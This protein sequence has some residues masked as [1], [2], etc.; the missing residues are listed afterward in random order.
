MSW[1][2][3]TGSALVAA[4]V[5]LFVLLTAF[6]CVQ[7]QRRTA[8][9][10]LAKAQS[11]REEILS[12]PQASS[13]KEELDLSA[14]YQEK[15]ESY[16]TKSRSTSS[17]ELQ[18]VRD[19]YDTWAE[20]MADLSLKKAREARTK[21]QGDRE[22]PPVE[23]PP[24]AAGE[25]KEEEDSSGPPGPLSLGRNKEPAGED[26]PAEKNRV[27]E[28]SLKA[29]PQAEVINPA[30][31]DLQGPQGPLKAD[32][33]TPQASPDSTTPPDRTS[34]EPT[35]GKNVAEKT[36][37]AREEEDRTARPPVPP[38]AEPVT[39]PRELYA[40]ALALYYDHDYNSSR[41]LF[42]A[43]LAQH[44][45][46]ALAVNSQYWIGETY[47]SEAEYVLALGAFEAVVNQYPDGVK[48]PDG[49]VKM[50]LSE[51]KLGRLRQGRK[52]LEE[53]LAR[54]PKSP[55]AK[56]ARRYLDTLSQ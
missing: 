44:P 3:R 10:K 55:A 14:R 53:C 20:Q 39:E 49:M 15:A 2:N 54:F 52:A 12:H 45:D 36:A 56:V 11:L 21:L 34:E 9:S 29:P 26:R 25:G 42:L 35:E 7:G 43:F 23:A 32:S 31:E 46:H 40:R 4:S 5:G 22:A 16:M 17:V 24:A 47:Y 33:S 51:L 41:R 1:R 13:V 50:G 30:R 38:E 37:P 19:R 18:G 8:E 27:E 28:Q 6:G 48:V